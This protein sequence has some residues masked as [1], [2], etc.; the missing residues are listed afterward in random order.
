MTPLQL[1]FD[2]AYLNADL[3]EEV[4]MRPP[5]G[6]ELPD[7]KLWKLVECLYGLRQSGKN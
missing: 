2:A 1:D 5:A 3:R 4:Y 7:G 6:Y